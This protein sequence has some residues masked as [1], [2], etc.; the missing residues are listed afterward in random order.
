[1]RKPFGQYLLQFKDAPIVHRNNKDNTKAV[2]ILDDRQDFWFM[3]TLKNY[4]YH[5]DDTW[6]FHI[7]CTDQNHEWLCGEL[8]MWAWKV[9]VHHIKEFMPD[10]EGRTLDLPTYINFYTTP[11]ILESFVEETFLTAQLDT[12]LLNPL[13]PKYLEYDFIGAPCGT[14]SMNGGCT[15][16][17]KSAML[18]VMELNTVP[19]NVIDDVWYTD[20]MRDLG[21]KLPTTEEAACF[22]VENFLIQDSKPFGFHGTNKYYVG[23]DVVNKALDYAS[24]VVIKKPRVMITSPVYKWPPHPK[25]IE[26]LATCE[27]DPRFDLSFRSIQGDAHIERARSMLLLQYLIAPEPHDWYVMIDS[28]IEFNADI[29]WGIINRGKDVIGAA[30]SFKA[31]EGNPKYQQP[32]IRSLENETPS[33]DGLIRV[34]HLGGGFT[35]VSDSFLKRMCEEYKDLEFMMN[36]DLLNGTSKQLTYGLWNP[37]LIDQLQWETDENGKHYKEMLSEDYSFCERVWMMGGEC[38]LDLNCFIAHWDGETCYQ[39]KLTSEVNSEK[40]N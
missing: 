15:I 7:V 31:G 22:V 28:D 25:F 4:R 23:N 14:N 8:G 38:W 2:I 33:G 18:K 39:L 26:S 34:R 13:D 35:V 11:S 5:L 20:K 24:P 3:A 10:H 19:D 6:N 32:V 29:I 36:P 37:L 40:V 30:Y 27:K 21:C 17:S 12:V 9:D 1:M 16:R